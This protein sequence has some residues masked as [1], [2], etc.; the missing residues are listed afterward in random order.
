MN[1][2]NCKRFGDVVSERKQIMS[3]DLS[4]FGNEN[5]GIG[6]IESFFC[7]N[8]SCVSNELCHPAKIQQ[9]LC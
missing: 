4:T 5:F 2:S 8:S 9:P 7:D 3:P 1:F 6:P